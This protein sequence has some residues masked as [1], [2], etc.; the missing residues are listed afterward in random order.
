MKAVNLS[1]LLC[2]GLIGVACSV[3]PKYQRPTVQVPNDYK[4]PPPGDFKEWKTANPQDHIQRGKWWEA[5]QDP[6]LNALEEQVNG[7]NQSIA[8]VEAQFRAARASIRVARADLFP[9]LSGNA[10]VTG[11][12]ASAHRSFSTGTLA[13]MQ[14]G[15]SASWEP[16]FWGRVRHNVEANIENAQASAGDLET[17]R[18]SL[19]AELATDYFL[20][21]G[22]DAQKQLLDS[23]AAA[24]KKAL[25]L[26]VNRY[27]QGVVSQV[28]VAQA[29]TQ[30][31]TTRAQATDTTVLRAQYEHAI[32]ILT[33]KPPAELTIGT[34]AITS[35]PPSIPGAL[36]SQLMERRPDIAAA[37]RRVAS[38]NAQIGVA[39]A[40]FYP[41]ITFNA[42][43]GLE[44]TSLLNLFTWPSRFWSLGPSASQLFLDGGRRRGV[45]DQAQ[46]SYDVA[47]ANYRETSLVAFQDVEDNLA[48]LRILTQ[49]S[50]EQADAVTAAERSLQLANNRYLGGITTYLEVITAQGAALANERTAV[51]V[52]TRRMT[53]SVALIKALGGGWEATALPSQADL[54]PKRA[55]TKPAPATA[56]P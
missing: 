27:N 8:A 38:A 19:H 37:E 32:A 9:T 56:R 18:L 40:A 48:A 53:A 39:Q 36:P 52:L 29:R 22:L 44:S 49:E 28:D 15:P 51:D 20:L 3:G 2:L 6:Q 25:D 33:G 16:D 10:A 54:L 12:Q 55:S 42:S 26:T 5:F 7:A 46:A 43:A 41:N 31:E 47:V 1:V 11:S 17:I 24:Y 50:I 45:T 23:T 14:F 35:K 34:T 21:H 30:L 13:D 4:E